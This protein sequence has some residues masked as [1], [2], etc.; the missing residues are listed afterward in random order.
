M[1]ETA[2]AATAGAATAVRGE[3]GFTWVV[4]QGFFGGSQ[5]GAAEVHPHLG[6]QLRRSWCAQSGVA[7][8][9]VRENLSK[10]R[11]VKNG[12]RKGIIH[13]YICK[14]AS[15]FEVRVSFWVPYSQLPIFFEAFIPFY[16]S[17]YFNTGRR[18]RPSRRR[19]SKSL[20][21]AP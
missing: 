11:A 12:E 8:D 20:L 21:Y 9:A 6:W 1:I 10:L 5:E 19:R 7:P 17:I 4:D 14:T 13:Y 16:Y 2:A 15:H 18:A 3:A